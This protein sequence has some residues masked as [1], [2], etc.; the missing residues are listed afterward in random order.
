MVFIRDILCGYGY[1]CRAVNFTDEGDL[2]VGCSQFALLF[3]MGTY[4]EKWHV[5][6]NDSYVRAIAEKKGNNDRSPL[7]YMLTLN[8]HL[9]QMNSVFGDQKKIQLVKD[10]FTNAGTKFCLSKDMMILTNCG[11]H[12]RI[13]NVMDWSKRDYNLANS[14]KSALYA[15]IRMEIF[16]RLILPRLY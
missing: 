16:S 8:R 7:I 3:D 1:I 14:P 13:V 2:L 6:V 12:I 4:T 9:N 10:A 11:C 5:N 15:C